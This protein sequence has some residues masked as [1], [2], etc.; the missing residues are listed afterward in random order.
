RGAEHNLEHSRHRVG[1]E[2]FESDE[3]VVLAL[4]G[5]FPWRQS[6]ECP[7]K[8]IL[9]GLLPPGVDCRQFS[10]QERQCV[11]SDC[12]DDRRVLTRMPAHPLA[13]TAALVG[14]LGPISCSQERQR[15]EQ[16][17]EPK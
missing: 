6:V 10:Q 14:W 11:S 8:K 15:N 7:S 13:Q 1:A 2:D 3:G 16:S 5:G 17:Y 4:A 12:L 9:Q